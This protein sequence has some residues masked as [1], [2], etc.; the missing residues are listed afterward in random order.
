MKAEE[1]VDTTFIVFAAKRCLSGKYK[2]SV[3]YFCNCTDKEKSETFTTT[4]GG[5]AVVEML[6]K[7]IAAE[8][9]KP[10]E[11]TLRFIKEGSHDGYYVIE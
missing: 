8:I 3:Y 1:L 4:L 9:N 11:I 6:D 7:Y 5:G 2:D 10:F